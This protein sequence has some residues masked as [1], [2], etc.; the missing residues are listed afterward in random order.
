MS[1]IASD[2]PWGL[3]EPCFSGIYNILIVKL[4]I[5]RQTERGRMK[6]QGVLHICY[7]LQFCYDTLIKLEIMFKVWFL[8]FSWA[9]ENVEH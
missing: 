4:H 3:K 1:T 9:I 8:F 7:L 2:V 5:S 6:K